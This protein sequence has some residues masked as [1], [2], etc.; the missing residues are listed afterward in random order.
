VKKLWGG[1]LVL[2][3]IL[4]AEDAKAALQSGVDAIV[5]SNHGGRQLDGAMSSIRALP[6]VVDTVADRLEVWFDGGIRSGQDVLRALALGAHATLVGR[7]YAYGLGA[8]GEAGVTR[9]LQIIQAELD[10]TM[11][12]CGLRSVREANPSILRFSP[13]TTTGTP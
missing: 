7:A 5:V 13:R 9:A 2:K 4:D 11:A 12:L 8:M 10:V 1:K 6:E 3:G